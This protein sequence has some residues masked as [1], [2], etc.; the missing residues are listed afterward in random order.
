M[1]PADLGFD[2]QKTIDDAL[3]L[4]RDWVP[5]RLHSQCC[6][7]GGFAVNPLLARDVDVFV[8]GPFGQPRY[9]I[10]DWILSKLPAQKDADY[11][12]FGHVYGAAVELLGGRKTHL[13]ASRCKNAKELVFSRFDLTPHCVAVNLA[14]GARIEHP[15]MRE[16]RVIRWETPELTWSRFKK[17]QARYGWST[18]FESLAEE[19]DRKLLE[20]LAQSCGKSYEK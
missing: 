9:E 18:E 17:L 15:W 8:F 20:S 5:S 4:L 11:I 13:I 1:I 3:I 16:R 12:T 7:A 2:P 6:I 14:S 10:D 19:E